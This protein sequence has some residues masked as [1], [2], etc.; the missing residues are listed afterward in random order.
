MGPMPQTLSLHAAT[1]SDTAWA[2]ALH[3]AAYRAVVLAQFGGWDEAQ[4][5]RCLAH[6]WDVSTFSIIL[7][8]QKPCGYACIQDAPDAV[9]LRELVVDP[10][11]QGRG[12]GTWVITRALTRS[13]AR[14]VA[15]HL[16]ALRRNRALELY[17]RLGFLEVSGTE[18]H[19]FLER[20]ADDR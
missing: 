19:L 7:C 16:G 1:S 10:A 14:Q 5:D 6:D 17:R 9:Q 8:D 11:C 20:A 15:T 3:H 2:C 12:I 18:T 4:Q 13:Q